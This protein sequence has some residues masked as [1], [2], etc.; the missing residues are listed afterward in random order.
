M[1][2]S[3]LL[4]ITVIVAAAQLSALGAELAV[5][6]NGFSIRHDRREQIGTLTRLYTNE[7][8]VDIPTDSIVSFEQEE[9]PPP[10]PVAD[11]KPAPATPAAQTTVAGPVDLDQVVRDASSKRQI[12]P[13]FVNSV[14]KAESNFHPRAVSPKGAQGL[15]QLMPDTAR[16]LQVTDPFDPEQNIRAGAKYLKQLLDRFK[17]DLP[18]ALAAYNAGAG[19]V[20]QA[21]GIPAID[22]TKAYV[23]A[24]LGKLGRGGQE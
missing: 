22:E 2:V 11:T 8:Y 14:I 1:K 15:M 18:R 24:I 23:E 16:E 3:K 17:G 19:A 13:D 6:R 12:D 4:A 20:D 7:G 5:L 10:Q 9:T 21:G